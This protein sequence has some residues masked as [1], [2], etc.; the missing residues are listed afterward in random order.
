MG[1]PASALLRLKDTTLGACHR[2]SK[3]ATHSLRSLACSSPRA[4]VRTVPQQAAVHGHHSSLRCSTRL[5]HQHQH[6]RAPHTA[7]A[8]PHSSVACLQRCTG[9]SL[10]DIVDNTYGPGVAP[11]PVAPPCTHGASRQ[12]RVLM[13]ATTTQLLILEKAQQ[14]PTWGLPSL[15]KNSLAS[16]L[17]VDAARTQRAALTLLVY[18][19]QVR[20]ARHPCRVW[21]PGLTSTAQHGAPMWAY[22][23]MA[24]R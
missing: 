3:P 5:P 7:H 19:G 1:L 13:P 18:V 2:V 4:S 23:I 24:A 21:Q 10:V 17:V 16:Y 20:A 12:G 22:D 14:Q 8:R 6:Q 15:K 9:H 11:V